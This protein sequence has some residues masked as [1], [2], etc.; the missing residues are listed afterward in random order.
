MHSMKA[1]LPPFRCCVVQGPIITV[2]G[3]RIALQ[4][5]T[6]GQE[7]F[8]PVGDPV[9]CQGTQL[10]YEHGTAFSHQPVPGDVHI[11]S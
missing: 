10:F 4:S 11:H 3:L 1:D 5:I 9:S 2:M 8:L 7:R 6:I